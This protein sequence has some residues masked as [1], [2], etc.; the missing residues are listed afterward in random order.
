MMEARKKVFDCFIILYQQLSKIH[1]FGVSYGIIFYSL[2][3]KIN[4]E[5]TKIRVHIRQKAWVVPAG[6][7]S[8]GFLAPK[9]R[10]P[11]NILIPTLRKKC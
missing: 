7:V 1:P 10:Y 11:S 8:Y 6:F 9:D 2:L 3:N 5:V 4:K